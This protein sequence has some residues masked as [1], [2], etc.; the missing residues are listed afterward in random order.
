VTPRCIALRQ[1]LPALADEGL[2]EAVLSVEGLLA[3]QAPHG[4]QRWRA[5][6]W[7][8]LMDHLQGHVGEVAD[9]ITADR[10]TGHPSAAHLTARAL[11]A[12]ALA[13]ESEP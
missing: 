1:L 12:L 9:G 11:M 5:L 8:E 2:L 13:L 6:D 7:P 3:S 4:R 10:D